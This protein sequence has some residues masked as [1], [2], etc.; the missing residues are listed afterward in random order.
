MQSFAQ[1]EDTQIDEEDDVLGDVI[2]FANWD[3][4]GWMIGKQ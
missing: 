2:F 1:S 3:D 4:R